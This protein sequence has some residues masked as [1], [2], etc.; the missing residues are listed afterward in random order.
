MNFPIRL[1]DKL[2]SVTETAA[3]GDF[4]PTAQAKAVQAE[5]FKAVDAEL[6]KLKTIWEKDLSELNATFKRLDT[7][8]ILLQ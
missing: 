7:P 1:N 4:A 8:A 5:H 6:Q 3:A 2:A